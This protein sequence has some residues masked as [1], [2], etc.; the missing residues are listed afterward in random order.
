M[1]PCLR[2][3]HRDTRFGDDLEKEEAPANDE[4]DGAVGSRAPEPVRD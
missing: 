2:D 4:N 1:L 3:V